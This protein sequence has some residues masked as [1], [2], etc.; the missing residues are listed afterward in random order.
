MKSFMTQ[1]VFLTARSARCVGSPQSFTHEAFPGALPGALHAQGIRRL[2]AKRFCSDVGVAQVRG[3][4]EAVSHVA[5]S[6]LQE[7]NQPGV[8]V[9]TCVHTEKDVFSAVSSR[10]QGSW[11][12]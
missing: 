4:S 3:H 5:V 11:Q 2:S 10:D 9:C 8:C 12:V 6:I 7:R 1:R